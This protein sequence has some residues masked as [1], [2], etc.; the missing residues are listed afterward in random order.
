MASLSTN[1]NGLRRVLFVDGAGERRGVHLGRLPQKAAEAFLRRV[2][3]LNANRIAGVSN[4]TELASW[5]RGLPDSIH[6]KLE[7]VALVEPRAAA[8]VRTVGELLD[9]FEQ[10]AVVK[11]S[12]RKAYKQTLDSLR[13]FLGAETAL[14]AVTA[15]TADAWRKWIATDTTSVGRKRATADNRLSPATCAKRTFV[16]RT[17]FR[18]AVR[19]KWIA[20]S[21]FEGVQAGSQANP[22]RAFYVSAEATTAILGRCPDVEWRSIVGLTRYAGL[23]CPSELAT[24]TWADIDWEAGRLT[25]RASKTE[26]H[27]GGHAV[28]HVPICPALRAILEEAF[29]QAAEGSTLVVPRTGCGNVNLRTTFEKIITRAGLVP[30]PRLFQNLRA[31]C[32]TDWVEAYPAHEVAAW[33]G[34][35]PAVAAAHYLQRRD[36]HFQD[37]VANGLR[38]DAQSDARGAQNRAQQVPARNRKEPQPSPEDDALLRFMRTFAASCGELNKYSVGD[39]GLEP[40]T[41]SV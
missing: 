24:L 21:P 5:V 18:K 11:P 31:S 9:T 8:T 39:E 3:E 30:W 12:T 36:H 4:S 13:A 25:V 22:S 35:S 20:T 1:S 29:E 32:E 38:G 10:R 16:A 33:M 17:V 27:G 26:H 15:E 23:R 2:E 37:V 28:R 34:H 7:R 19:W 40:P 41:P 6:A 14:Q